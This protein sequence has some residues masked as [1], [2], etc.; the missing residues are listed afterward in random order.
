MSCDRIRNGRTWGRCLGVCPVCTLFYERRLT[1][2][3][4]SNT[5]TRRDTPNPSLKAF[6]IP[7]PLPATSLH[8]FPTAKIIRTNLETSSPSPA[9][10]PSPTSGQLRIHVDSAK[11]WIRQK[12][13]KH[14]R[15]PIHIHKAHMGEEGD[16]DT[17]SGTCET[18]ILDWG[19]HGVASADYKCR[20]TLAKQHCCT[21]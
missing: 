21:D 16:T 18:A 13:S 7:V 19:N 5:E 9:A 2:W 14:G 15:L 11:R 10:K 12:E 17:D 4:D 8:T 3:P 20:I 1:F 6:Q